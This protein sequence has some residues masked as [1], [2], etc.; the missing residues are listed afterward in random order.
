MQLTW[1]LVNPLG[2]QVTDRDDVWNSGCVRDVLSLDPGRVIVA[3]DTGGVWLADDQGNGFPLA[4]MEE[5]DL[6]CLA[7]DEGS[8]AHPHLYAAGTALWET[9]VTQTAPLLAWR[10]IQPLVDETGADLGTV[11][12]VAVLDAARQVVLATSTGIYSSSIPA[13]S[14]QPADYQWQRAGGVASGGYFG[15]ALGLEEVV[16]DRALRTVLA[17]SWGVDGNP[18]RFYVGHW[19]RIPSHIHHYLKLEFRQARFVGATFRRS[20]LRATSL[21]SSDADHARAYAVSSDRDG[22]VA[23]V[24]RSDDGGNSW[25]PLTPRLMNTSPTNPDF[26]ST[27]GPQGNNSGRP[28]NCIAASRVDRDTVVIG[29]RH[30][31]VFVSTD[32]GRR[33]RVTDDSAHVHS[34]IHTVYFDPTD[35]A[36]TALYVG[37]DGGL[38]RMGDLGRSTNSFVSMFNRSLATLQFQS[39]P[40]R[41]FYGTFTPSSRDWILAGGLQD[42]GCV[43]CLLTPNV[44]PWRE[45]GPADDG[46]NAVFLESGAVVFDYNDGPQARHARWDRSTKSFDTAERI[47]IRRDAPHPTHHPGFGLW[48]A[49]IEPVRKVARDGQLHIYAIGGAASDVFGLFSTP[50]LRNPFWDLLVR[51]A[52]LEARPYPTNDPRNFKPSIT[53][54]ASYEGKVVFVGSAGGRLFRYIH[55]PGLRELGVPPR[56][57]RN[58]D[59]DASIDHIAVDSSVAFASFNKSGRGHLLRVYPRLAP[60]ADEVALPTTDV[61]YGIEVFPGPAGP[62]V[63]VATDRDV[64]FSDDLGKCWSDASAGL[65]RTPHCADVRFVT[66]PDGRSWLYLATYGRSVWRSSLDGR[67]G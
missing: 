30:E 2:I 42:N 20:S 16:D 17:A 38:V 58:G 45:L 56:Q 1:S 27:A 31:G 6:W 36:G 5:P 22:F 28:N 62:L 52:I 7:L 15:L 59:K 4:D 26:R 14:S 50:T 48:D 64:F 19:R 57:W 12:R 25:S 49:R 65:P 10:R 29:W 60:N 46:H 47:R 54:V 67:D 21:A 66:M 61:I 33:F 40:A 32:K 23:T 55:G 24:F 43:Y 63:V 3:T 51:I 9:D 18:T 44:D 13:P 35:P 8:S 53:A 37:G 34:D 11:Y 39:S 41:Q